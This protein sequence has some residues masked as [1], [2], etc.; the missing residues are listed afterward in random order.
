M[1]TTLTRDILK[2]DI[3]MDVARVMAAANKR[4]RE[5]GIDL[6]QS[7]ITITQVVD[8]GVHWRV[9]YG[10]KEYIGRRGGDLMIDIDPRD[11]SVKRVLRGQ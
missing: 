10:P 4:A 11:A 8:D 9:T 2:D 1:A 7:L 6:I 5:S 3:A